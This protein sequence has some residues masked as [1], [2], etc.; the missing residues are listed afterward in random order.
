MEFAVWTKG[1]ATLAVDCL[2]VGVFEEGELGA[3]ARAVDAACGGRL[4]ALLARGDFAGRAGETLLVTD[5][6]GLKAARVLL[7][8][9]GA[10]SSS[11]AQGLAQGL[12]RRMRRPRPHPHRQ[13]SRSPSTG[14]RRASSMTTTSDARSPSS[15]TA[16]STASTILKT[17]KKPPA[18]ALARRCWPA[19]CASAEAAARGLK[20]GAAIA[21]AARRAARSRQPAGQ[22]LHA[23][24][25]RRAGA[26]ARQAPRR[27][28]ACGCWTRR[29]SAARRWAACS[30][31]RRAGAAAALHRARVPRRRAP[32]RRRWCWSARA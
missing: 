12:E 7:T 13:L 10:A 4:K 25:P 22:R 16:R 26:R 14:R 23:D 17:G 15:R 5:L 1:L 6:P 31:S 3:E 30:P 19:R 28:S 27:R 11:R 32:R 9:L 18:P 29:R 2:V 24:V 20:H 21:A 8:G